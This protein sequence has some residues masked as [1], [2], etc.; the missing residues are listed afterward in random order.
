MWVKTYKKCFANLKKEDIWQIWMDV[1]NWPQWDNE[2]KFCKMTYNFSEGKS[3]LLKP[4]KGP[5]VT[6]KLLEVK[7]HEKFKATCNFPLAILYDEHK[8]EATPEGLCIIRTISITGFLSH[9]WIYL[10]GRKMVKM[11]P[12]QMDALAEYARLK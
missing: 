11:I 10:V 7:H 8:L 6:I 1:N 5:I 3:F 2:L 4:Q 9:L 12:A